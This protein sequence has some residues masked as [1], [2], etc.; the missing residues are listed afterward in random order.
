MSQMRKRAC[1]S[2]ALFAAIVAVV[3]LGAPAAGATSSL[4]AVSIA[5]TP[6]TGTV[7]GSLESGGV[8]VVTTD[9]GV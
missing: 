5:L 1:L 4:P 8:N 3:C 7:G 6:T 2:G 9:T